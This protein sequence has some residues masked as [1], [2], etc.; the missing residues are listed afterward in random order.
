[1]A[2]EQAGLETITEEET[3]VYKLLSDLLIEADPEQLSDARPMSQRFVSVKAYQ[4][5]G[6]MQVWGGNSHS[7]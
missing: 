4:Y 5:T 3:K 6:G 2:V 1:M 7:P